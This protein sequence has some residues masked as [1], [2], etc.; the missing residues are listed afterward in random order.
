MQ[1]YSIVLANGVL[2]HS[3]QF[4]SMLVCKAKILVYI[5]KLFK[6]VGIRCK[7]IFQCSVAQKRF[8]LLLWEHVI[9]FWGKIELSSTLLI[10]ITVL[11]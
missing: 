10:L 7:H 1:R 5:T 4:T 3:Y 8:F 11:K 2:S 9:E 6:K